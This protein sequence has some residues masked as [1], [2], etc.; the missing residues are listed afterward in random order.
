MNGIGLQE[1]YSLVLKG[2]NKNSPGDACFAHQVAEKRQTPYA[3][4]RMTSPSL[5]SCGVV[6]SIVFCLM[7][8][9]VNALPLG[10]SQLARRVEVLKR[11]TGENILTQLEYDWLIRQGLEPETSRT[12]KPRI[13]RSR[14]HLSDQFLDELEAQWYEDQMGPDAPQPSVRRN[15]R[16]LDVNAATVN[17]AAN[18]AVDS[19]VAKEEVSFV[20][21]TIG[22]KM[23]KRSQDTN[24]EES[25]LARLLFKEE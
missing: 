23:K 16:H 11:I 21:A 4:K 9:E 13:G 20:P 14:R 8:K 22:T 17:A 19:D 25:F 10:E 15:R 7:N 24:G 5:W 6:I 3:P 1:R 2:T 18:A 12:S